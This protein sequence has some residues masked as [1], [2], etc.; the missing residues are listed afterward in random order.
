MDFIEGETLEKSWNGYDRAAKLQIAAQLRSYI[1]QLRSIPPEDY[2]G[3][4]N[5][6]PVT[7]VMLEWSP[8]SKGWAMH[9][10]LLL[11]SQL[12]ANLTDILKALSRMKRISTMQLLRHTNQDQNRPFY[13]WHAKQP[14]PQGN[15]CPW[16]LNIIVRNEHVVAI[17][18]WE[19]SGWY[20]EY[21]EFVK[22]SM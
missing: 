15:V 21:W 2:I 13:S 20:P 18:D 17:I 12:F 7:D 4:V 11:L 10:I 22:H 1:E 8:P 14:Q 9:Q 6:G 19:M 3:S 5:R 16:R